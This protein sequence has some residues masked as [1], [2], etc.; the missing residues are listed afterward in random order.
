MPAPALPV[1]SIGV[2]SHLSAVPHSD[3]R[4]IVRYSCDPERTE[5]LSDRV[6]EIVG[7]WR[8]APPEDKFA[9]DIAAN[10]RRSFSENLERNEWWIGQITFAAATDADPRDLMNRLELYDS[11]T[12]EVLSE[13]AE[14]YMNDSNYVEAVLFPQ[15]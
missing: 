4:I 12:P 14:K 6:K 2:Y 5:E 10:Q 15:E 1:W 13:T 9:D 8:S 11:L 3:Y 7:Q